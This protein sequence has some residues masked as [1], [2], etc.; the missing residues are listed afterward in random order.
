[1]FDIKLLND[2]SDKMVRGS[3][4]KIY[5]TGKRSGISTNAVVEDMFDYLKNNSIEDADTI[6][7]LSSLKTT[8]SEKGDG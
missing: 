6:L 7:L 2:L 8:A 1:M 4:K 3:L 5:M